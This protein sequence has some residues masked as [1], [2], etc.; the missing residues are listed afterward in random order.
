MSKK[1]F[2]SFHADAEGT[3]YKNL[4]VAWSENDRK[5]FDISFD[6]SS[7]GV[8]INSTN[9]TYIKTVI[10]DKIKA[11]PTF[12]CLIG[13]TTYQSEWVKWEIEKAKRELCDFIERSDLN[14]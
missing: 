7:V 5:H 3:L 2:I 6:D 8:S 9:A 12:L 11:S 4:L 1:L 10:G 13:K 14:G